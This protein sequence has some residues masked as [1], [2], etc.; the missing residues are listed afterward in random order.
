MPDILLTARFGSDPLPDPSQPI[1]KLTDFGLARAI[2]PADPWLRTRCGSES[3][4]APELLLAIATSDDEGSDEE[5]LRIGPHL[6]R[7][8]T[9]GGR[10]RVSRIGAGSS[11]SERHQPRREGAYDGRETDAWALGVVLYAL[12]SR[13]LPFNPP[14]ELEERLPRYAPAREKERRDGERRAWVKRVLACRVEWPES[15]SPPSS[16]DGHDGHE[17]AEEAE[18]AGDALA[19]LEPVRKIVGRLLV[20][21][22]TARA[23]CAELLDAW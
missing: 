16:S 18:I 17:D 8:P 12:A 4:A 7:A 15:P 19:T 3:Y 13:A 9:D 6:S 10:H 20:R 14:P 11:G 23:T 5:L 22:P 1:L 2:D 21:D